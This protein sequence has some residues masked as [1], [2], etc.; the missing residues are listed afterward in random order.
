[1]N[2]KVVVFVIG[3]M[4]LPLPISADEIPSIVFIGA[5]NTNT[6]QW[7][8]GSYVTKLPE[9]G[10]PWSEMT[11][12]NAGIDGTGTYTYYNDSEFL[13]LQAQN[14]TTDFIFL[15]LGGNDFLRGTN[16]GVFQEQIDWI[17]SEIRNNTQAPIILAN[18]IWSPIQVFDFLFPDEV[19]E[20]H[21]AYQQILTNQT[22]ENVFTVDVYNATIDQIDYYADPIH[23]NELG[24][25][26]VANA[27]HQ[28][29]ADTIIE[30]L[31][32]IERLENR[33]QGI[34]RGGLF[35]VLMLILS[36]PLLRRRYLKPQ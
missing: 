36:Y 25:Q 34:F 27:I 22:V 14:Y 29:L 18:L 3:I 23:L 31:A 7:A 33:L 11:I 13:K 2:R 15:M 17:L 19:R 28:Q 32:K 10:L 20:A 4:L 9:K 16:P 26:S 30:I 12:T 8:N 5:S 24:H 1:M 21:T 6:I 35:L